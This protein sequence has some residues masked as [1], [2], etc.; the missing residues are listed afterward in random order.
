VV[1]GTSGILGL[2]GEEINDRPTSPCIR[3]GT[4]VTICPCG[5]SPVEMSAFIRKDNLE[6]ATNLG[7]MDC[8]SCG[9]CSWVCPSHIPLVHYFNYAKGKLNGID[10]ERRK[11]ERVKTLVEARNIRVEKVAEARK[12]ALAAKKIAAEAPVEVTPAETASA[13]VASAP[14]PLAEEKTIA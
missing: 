3:C 10:R 11:N 8:I 4:C 5:L 14:A 7:I 9:S 1:K 2:T 12:A 13:P 6:G